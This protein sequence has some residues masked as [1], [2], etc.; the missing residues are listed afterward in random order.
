MP[1]R[2]PQFVTTTIVLLSQQDF[3]T[4]RLYYSATITAAG[5]RLC[6]ATIT[7]GTVMPSRAPQFVTTRL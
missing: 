6:S 7:A 4:T 1:S 5:T 3:V 2:A